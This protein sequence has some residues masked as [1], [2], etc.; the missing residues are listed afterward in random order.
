MLSM[1][2]PV[3][4]YLRTIRR[5]TVWVETCQTVSNTTSGP[6]FS[7][8]PTTSVRITFQ[9]NLICLKM[10]GKDGLSN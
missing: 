7:E 5:R 8:S 10:V 1:E 3:H 6:K 2:N 4:A 9:C